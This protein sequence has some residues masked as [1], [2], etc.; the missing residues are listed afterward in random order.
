MERIEL[1]PVDGVHITTPVDNS[2]DLLLLDEGLVRR[3]GIVGSAGEFPVVPCGVALEGSTVDVLRAEHGFSSLVEIHERGASHRVLFDARV[4]PDGL[5]ADLDR[6]GIDPATFEAIVLSHG[7]F[8]H[9]M[10]LEG[11]ARRLGE[12]RMPLLLHPDFWSR[13]RIASPTRS[14][15]LP[16]PGRAGIQDAGFDIVEGAAPSFLLWTGPCWSPVRWSGPAT[17]RRGSPRTR[18][19]G[20]G[21][22][23][24]IR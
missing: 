7:H 14:F 23:C 8:D 1:R 21:R 17:S 12:R 2:S 15:A 4:T 16:A 18:R 24:R 3:W 13:R 9:V 19:G 5:I 11:L 20:T 10:G 22:G 6:M